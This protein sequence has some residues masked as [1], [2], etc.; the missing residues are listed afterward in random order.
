MGT[1]SVLY[2]FAVLA[3]FVLGAASQVAEGGEATIGGKTAREVFLA[4]QS[5][6]LVEAS[7]RGNLEKMDALSGQADVNASGYRD[8]TPLFWTMACK[9]YAGVE[10][11]L[12][13]GADP[14]YKMEGDVSATWAAAGSDDPHFLPLMLDH[15]GNP[16][17]R[18]GYR[19][20]LMIAIQQGHM[21][22]VTLLL[23]RGAD[24]NDH[25]ESG[26]TAAIAAAYRPDFDLVQT[27]LDRGYSYDLQRL[28]VAVNRQG[29]LDGQSARKQKVLD[30]LRERGVKFP[31]S[32][33]HTARPPSS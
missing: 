15:G 21:N 23:Q 10:K 2:R 5:L 19:N 6:A 8:M 14:N 13:M 18:S 1:V 24:V 3:L 29:A 22:N 9:N 16:N 17:I 12:K 32:P 7:C 4:P 25:D 27:L 30:S 11:L 28:A 31:L 20:A 33:P 26:N